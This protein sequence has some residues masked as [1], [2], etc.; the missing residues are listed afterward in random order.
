MSFPE[1]H[2]IIRDSVQQTAAKE[3][4]YNLVNA[5][6]HVMDGHRKDQVGGQYRGLLT[7]EGG[8][9]LTVRSWDLQ[10]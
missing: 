3:I 5:N 9:Q 7:P 8:L 10:S 1:L 6:S 4:P 2:Y